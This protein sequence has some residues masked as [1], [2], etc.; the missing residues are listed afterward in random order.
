MRTVS[1]GKIIE[2]SQLSNVLNSNENFK[3]L[4]VCLSNKDFSVFNQISFFQLLATRFLLQ[5]KVSINNGKGTY[6]MLF[7]IDTM[8]ILNFKR[9]NVPL[10]YC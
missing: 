4:K 2:A 8:S 5:A 9:R 1:K 10:S 7:K 6:T 3:H